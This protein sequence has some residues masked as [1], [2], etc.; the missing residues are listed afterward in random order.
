MLLTRWLSSPENRFSVR[1]FLTAIAI[2]FRWPV[3]ANAT[4]CLACR[5]S[6]TGP[7]NKPCNRH[8]RSLTGNRVWSYH[9]AKA[10]NSVEYGTPCK[11]LGGEGG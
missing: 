9:D 5:H 8:S 3:S 1:L 11:Y 6:V 10:G 2:A 4:T 7:H